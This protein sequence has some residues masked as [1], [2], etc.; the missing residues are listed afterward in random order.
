MMKI[1]AD[2]HTHTIASGHAYG[3]IREMAFAAS[4]KKL[5]MLGIT[6]HAP[7]IPGTVDPFYYCNLSVIP[8]ELYGVQMLFGSEVNVLNNGTLSLSQKDLDRL[9]YAIAGIHTV[10][11]EDAG[12]EGNTDNLIA[13]MKNDKVCFV[14]HPDDDHTPLNYERLVNAAKKYHV[15]LEVNNSSLKKPEHRL[16]CF[17]NYRKMLALCMKYEVP[18]IVSSDA[19]DP[20]GVGNFGLAVSLIEQCEFDAGLILNTDIKKVQQFIDGR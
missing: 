17:E 14:S 18:V 19:H 16:N 10:C 15:A 2:L 20:S 12:I 7:G 1:V 13:C 3:T 6:E 5:L 4:E 11:Y 9:D 8:R